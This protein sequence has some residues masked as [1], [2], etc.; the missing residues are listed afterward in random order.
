MFYVTQARWCLPLQVPAL[1]SDDGR[2]R[3]ENLGRLL[4]EVQVLR[5]AQESTEE[6]LRELRQ[7]GGGRGGA[8]RR[9]R[10]GKGREDTGSG[11]LLPLSCLGALIQ[12]K[13]AGS[14]D[15]VLYGWM[16]IRVVA[17]WGLPFGGKWRLGS[18]QMPQHPPAPSRRQNEILWREVV[19]LRQSH[20]Q[21]HRVIGKVFLSP[22]P[23]PPHS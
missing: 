7:C 11:Q 8:G 19:T 21:Q 16:I 15:S 18:S 4:G 3:P 20:G 6:Q 14:W 9:R 17:G 12:T 5:G 23:L 22:T 1:R 10:G 2:W 13:R